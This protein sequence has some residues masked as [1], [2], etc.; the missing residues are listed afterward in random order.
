MHPYLTRLGVR[1][2]VQ[3]FFSPFYHS[4][5]DGNLYFAYTVGFEHYG[6]AFHRLPLSSGC[7]L[8]GN[9]SLA[10]VSQVII[11]TS[12]MGAIAWLELH[13]HKITERHSLLFFSAGG[14]VQTAHIDWLRKNCGNKEVILALG[15][16]PLSRLSALQLAAGLRGFALQVCYL[17]EEKVQIRFRGHSYLLN[18]E[19]LSLNAFEKMSGFRFR[20]LSSTPKHHSTFFEQLKAAAGLSF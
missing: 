10:Q 14:A 18:L 17:A 15:N 4:D 11:C 19:K 13:A 7:W 1:Q 16:D 5:G 12:S 6:L 2:A 20:V 8:A 9:L 3:D